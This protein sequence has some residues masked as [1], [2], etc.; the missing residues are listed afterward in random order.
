MIGVT[1]IIGVAV[2]V[3][4]GMSSGQAQTTIDVSK[5]TCYQFMGFKVAD[6]QKISIWLSGY[7][8]G[9]KNST[10]LEPQKLDED[11]TRVNSYCNSNPNLPVMQAVEKALLKDK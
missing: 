4:G 7:Y 10:V 3:L 8:H 5:I 6:P 1:R 9:Q 2:V 11:A